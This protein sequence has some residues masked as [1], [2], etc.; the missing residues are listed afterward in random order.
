MITL[1]ETAT[2]AQVVVSCQLILSVEGKNCRG[3]KRNLRQKEQS[4]GSNMDDAIL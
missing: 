2:Y 3:R 4:R 1:A